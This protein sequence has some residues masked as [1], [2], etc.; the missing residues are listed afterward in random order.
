MGSSDDDK[1]QS[2]QHNSSPPKHV[3]HLESSDHCMTVP[4]NLHMPAE[5]EPHSCCLILYP[6][7]AMTFRL[8]KAQAQFDMVIEAIAKQGHETVRIL[9]QSQEQADQLMKTKEY[10]KE[11]DTNILVHVVPSNDT[12]ARDTCPTFCYDDKHQLVGVDWQFNAYGGPEEGCYWPCDLD[13]EIP[14][15]VCDILEHTKRIDIP[16]VLEGGSIHTDGEGTILTT[17]ECLLNKNRNPHLSQEMIE[18]MALTTLGAKKMIWLPHGVDGDEDTNGHIDN[19]CC[20]A[21][22]GHVLLSW[23][24][25]EEN[26]RENYTRCRVASLKLQSEHDAKGREL[27]IH[28]LHLPP[29]I[30]YTQEEADSLK[31]DGHA[32]VREPGERMAASY[33]NFYI[34]NKAIIVPQFGCED[35]DAAAIHT[36][37]KVFAEDHG[38]REVVGVP[39]REILIGGG[40]I[41]CITQ[42]VPAVKR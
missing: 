39:S 36:L 38:G 26:D 31:G 19:F 17:M 11:K 35:T 13:C 7:N 34:A 33:C 24:D 9:C 42:Q 12:W 23:T 8:D 22:P 16:L 28:K 2:Q 37:Q 27:K 20:F 18:N 32:A 29:P 6:H 4:T 30:F 40:N 1:A 5:W 21:K 41:H 3:S 14:K 10:L 15:Q 25:D